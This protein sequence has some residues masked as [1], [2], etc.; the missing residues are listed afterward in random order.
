MSVTEVR[1]KVLIV[2]YYWVPSGGSGVQRFLKFTKYL[3]EFG[4][5]PVIYTVENGEYP[6]IDNSLEKDVPE[7]LTVIRQPI[8]EPYSFYKRFVGQKQSER[9][10]PAFF[11][12]KKKP[13][14]TEK[15]SVW[16]RG[17]FFIPDA[18]MFWIK[19][20]VKFLRKY[21]KENRVDAMISTGPPH[22][23]HR[24]AY[25]LH[26]ELK[27]PWLADFRDPWT[28]IDFYHELMLTKWA[29]K[30]HHRQEKEVLQQADA[31][32]V[33]GETMKE[34][35]KKTVDR[36]IEVIMN[37]YDEGDLRTTT[38][39]NILPDK[40]FSIVHIGTMVKAR[41]PVVL[42]KALSELVKENK[43]FTNHLEIK[44]IGKVDVNARE[45]IAAEGLTPFLTIIDYLPHDEVIRKQQE[46]Q[47]L[48]LMVNDTPT[49][50]GIVTGK[51]F[52]Y[53]ASRRPVLCI[54]PYDGD[55]AK[56]LLECEAGVVNNYTD[57]QSLKEHLLKFYQQYKNGT[58]RVESK[59]YEKYSRR[60]LTGQL[61]TVLNQITKN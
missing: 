61:A 50:K 29:D 60:N 14:F 51:M 6:V 42:W 47:L 59:G 44:L 32:T 11:T 15:F 5:E 37:G 13:K 34:E 16:L 56:I 31:V 49:S 22:S 2:T 53:L 39:G 8:W 43:E 40:K 57:V 4:W 46:A 58:L 30:K 33:I 10:N 12:E 35:F 9:M 25:H 36:Q 54:G 1:R 26:Q 18:R 24:I 21:L 52:E 41:N 48:L 45:N 7:N 27:I 38:A 20:S 19:P 28:Q 23:A 55:A 17:N 3:R